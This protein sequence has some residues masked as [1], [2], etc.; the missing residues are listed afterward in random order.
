[1]SFIVN[2]SSGSGGLTFPINE[3]LGDDNVQLDYTQLR[4]EDTNTGAVG[5][6]ARQAIDLDSG[7][8]RITIDASI[9]QQEIRGPTAF[10]RITDQQINVD[11]SAGGAGV[12]ILGSNGPLDNAAFLRLIGLTSDLYLSGE[13][14]ANANAGAGGALPATVEGY[15]I[16]AVAGGNQIRIP[17]FLP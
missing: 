11:D 2:P 8:A 14:A 12:A 17:Y 1:M 3:T 13:Q 10:T 16:A 6:Y 5:L 15:L 7:F 9:P 4:F